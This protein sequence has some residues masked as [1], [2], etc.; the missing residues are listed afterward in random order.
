M[1]RFAPTIPATLAVAPRHRSAAVAC[2]FVA[3]LAAGAACAPPAF[4]PAVAPVQAGGAQLRA[5]V[6]PSVRA[7]ELPDGRWS[8]AFTLAARDAGGARTAAL[9][10]HAEH[11][12][13]PATGHCCFVE[14]PASFNGRMT[15]FLTRHGLMPAAA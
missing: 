15:D 3:A 9:I 6:P 1:P 7:T 8:L 2:A 11:V 4:P 10:A 14:D 5:V 13:L 12:I